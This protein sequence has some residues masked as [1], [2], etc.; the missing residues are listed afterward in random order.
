MHE[1]Y[2]S[3]VCVG[4]AKQYIVTNADI[5]AHLS[6]LETSVIELKL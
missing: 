1:S 2:A 3:C 5:C 4:Y 6:S